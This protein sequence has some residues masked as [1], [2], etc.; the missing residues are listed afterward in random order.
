MGASGKYDRLLAPASGGTMQG[1]TTSRLAGSM[2]DGAGPAPEATSWLAPIHQYKGQKCRASLQPAS[3][4]SCREGTQAS[5]SGVSGVSC[6][7][8][9]SCGQARTGAAASQTH[10]VCTDINMPGAGPPVHNS[11]HRHAM[12]KELSSGA[13][14]GA[15]RAGRACVALTTPSRSLSPMP[16]R[17]ACT[18]G[19]GRK[20]VQVVSIATA[21]PTGKP[22]QA[23]RDP[24][25]AQSCCRGRP[26]SERPSAP[27]ASPAPSSRSARSARRRGAAP[28]SRGA[29]C[30]AGTCGSGGLGGPGGGGGFISMLSHAPDGW[31]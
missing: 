1:S 6:R 5:A 31:S 25:R 3:P 27:A 26:R 18:A 2:R 30:P 21:A 19:A 16:L 10:A 28:R 9:S 15:S 7:S 14:A 4:D 8:L 13:A 17:T 29:G 24:H 23:G 12:F 20:A 22:K 11:Q